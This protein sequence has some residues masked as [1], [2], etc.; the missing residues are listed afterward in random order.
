MGIWRIWNFQRRGNSPVV[1]MIFVEGTILKPKSWFSLYRCD[2]YIPIG[3]CVSK[4]QR[5]RSKG[6]R[7]CIVPLDGRGCGVLRYC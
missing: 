3:E 5:G 2:R 1:I 6:L 7:S 4:L